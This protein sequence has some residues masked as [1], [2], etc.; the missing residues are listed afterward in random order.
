M[1]HPFIHFPFPNHLELPSVYAVYTY[2]AVGDRPEWQLEYSRFGLALLSRPL[3]V[4]I[5]AQMAAD[6]GREASRE[7]DTV[8][9]IDRA[10]LGGAWKAL[11][12]QAV[13]KLFE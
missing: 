6:A 4:G 8:G 11:S 13:A 1:F 3:Y 7:G 2:V 9:Q 5:L 12:D 10:A